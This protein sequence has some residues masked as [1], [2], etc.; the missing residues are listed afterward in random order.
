MA[1]KL[2]SKYDIPVFTDKIIV[3][4][5]EIPHSHPVLTLSTRL[6]DKDPT[7][8][9]EVIV[10]EQFHWFARSHQKH[11]EVISYLKQRYEDNGE[12][13]RS[14]K[15]PDSFW[16]HII[17]IFN[18]LNTFKKMISKEEIKFIFEQWQPYPKTTQL[19]EDN[20][21]KIREE[22]NKFEMV[23]E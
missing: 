23:Y 12:C 16:E 9:L 6:K 14:G 11:K 2:F 17:V 15:Y 3:E 18:T 19:V 7:L 4:K 22:L 20:F 13:N 10:H 21:K 5:G 8:L 1:K